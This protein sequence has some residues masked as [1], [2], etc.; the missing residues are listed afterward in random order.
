MLAQMKSVARKS[1]RLREAIEANIGHEAGLGG[2]SHVTLA[3]Q[4]MRSLGITELDGMPTQT[5]TREATEW[6]SPDFNTLSEG[7]VAGWL[8]VAE[9]LV[10][11][12][13]AALEPSFAALGA[14]TRYLREHIHVDADEHA[15]WMAESVDEIVDLYGPDCCADIHEGMDI[16]WHETIQVP[17]AL[18]R[19]QCASA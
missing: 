18:W 7:N 15:Q 19:S 4:F 5:F 11:L 3:V 1:R 13:F 16:G 14:D 12:M 2:E 9:T 17:D 10:P 8:L 6:L